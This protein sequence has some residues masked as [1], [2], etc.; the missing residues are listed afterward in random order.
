MSYVVYTELRSFSK[1]VKLVIASAYV[2]YLH[3]NDHFLV[4]PVSLDT[5]LGRYTLILTQYKKNDPY[6]PTRCLLQ[7]GSSPYF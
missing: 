1:I 7:I 2:K 4:Y 6:V 5:Y 3:R